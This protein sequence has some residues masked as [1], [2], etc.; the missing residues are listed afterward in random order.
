MTVRVNEH[1]EPFVKGSTS[2]CLTNLQIELLYKTSIVEFYKR[3]EL[4]EVAV[5]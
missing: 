3:V 1:Y 2:L 5:L 4:S